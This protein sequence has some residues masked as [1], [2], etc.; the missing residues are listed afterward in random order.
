MA[1][2][3]K[4]LRNA[5]YVAGIFALSAV[6]VA[7]IY[8]ARFVRHADA[9]LTAKNGIAGVIVN[10]NGTLDQAWTTMDAVQAASNQQAAYS[11][12]LLASLDKANADLGKLGEATDQLKT[13]LANTDTQVNG[14]LLPS[15]THNVV[16]MEYTIDALTTDA[17]VLRRT[18]D[19]AD[20]QVSSPDIPATLK[21][22]RE[23][24]ANVASMTA[25]TDAT[26]GDIQ[27]AVH[28]WT[29]PPHGI[30]NLIKGLLTPAAH[31]AE[32]YHFL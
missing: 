28:R 25:H 7:G 5:L 20:A 15:L 8:A 29:K 18:L 16:E 2:L 6:G 11:T 27:A 3:R 4:I 22:L 21:N 32:L 24:S 19:H 12:K 13:L 26:A 17:D 10:L 31:A 1:R 23:T 30:W 9:L 14:S